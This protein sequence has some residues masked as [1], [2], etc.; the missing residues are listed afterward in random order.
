MKSVDALLDRQYDPK[1]Y[2]CV[3]FL[4]EAA[5]YLFEK[6]YSVSFLGLTG[7]LKQSIQTSRDTTIKN[8]RIERPKDG[9]I[10]LM[11]N[12]L[13]SSHVGLFYCGRVLHLS[14]IGVHFQ[15]L[16]SLERNYSRFRFYEASYLSQ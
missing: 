3:H 8:K 15:E 9:C 14:E 7:D 12:L 2:H 1:K 5:Q 11:T 4:I 13:N 6:D 16:R 10:V